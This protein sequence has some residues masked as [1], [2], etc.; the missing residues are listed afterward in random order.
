MRLKSLV[1][2]VVV[3]HVVE[4]REVENRW[5]TGWEVRVRKSN[6][7]NNNLFVAETFSHQLKLDLGI[8][9]PTSH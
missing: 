2:L 5:R 9:F 1:V 7:G 3:G 6:R 4:L 8:L